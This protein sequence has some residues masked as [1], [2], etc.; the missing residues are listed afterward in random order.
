MSDVFTTA[1]I[2]A[3]AEAELPLWEV[4]TADLNGQPHLFAIID[5]AELDEVM[6][7]FGMDETASIDPN[8]M[9]YV[10]LTEEQLEGLSGL[11]NDAACLLETIYKDAGEPDYEPPEAAW[12][13]LVQ[14]TLPPTGSDR[15][16][17]ADNVH[18][19]FADEM[20]RL[21]DL[22]E[23]AA[24]LAAIT[25]ERKIVPIDTP[26]QLTFAA[27]LTRGLAILRRE[28]MGLN[29]LFPKKETDQ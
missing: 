20:D 11:T 19:A 24:R 27:E 6:V 5:D 22:F 25:Q 9:S 1:Q 7:H 29:D 16:H 21:A 8:G 28:G 13:Q 2:K 14:I 17:S 3:I 12:R 18:R 23:N 10:M 4:I 26:Q 15:S